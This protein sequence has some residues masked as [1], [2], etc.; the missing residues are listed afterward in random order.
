MPRT[1]QHPPA[2]RGHFAGQSQADAAAAAGDE[3]GS[4]AHSGNLPKRAAAYQQAPQTS[5]SWSRPTSAA[6]HWI[7]KLGQYQRAKP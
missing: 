7:C 3:N 5:E 6:M 2:P 1:G 4:G